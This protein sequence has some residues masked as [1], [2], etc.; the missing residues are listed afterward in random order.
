MGIQVEFNPDLALRAFG[1]PD[2]DKHE[3]LPEK[4]EAGKD[5]PFVKQGQRLYWLPGDIPL[6]ETKGNQQLSRPLA[7]I[8]I[9]H[10]THFVGLSGLCTKGVYRVNEVYDLNDKTIHFEGMNKIK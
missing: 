7:S 9:I 1:T 10:A 2:R 3:C 5:Y 4:L 8:R 6:F